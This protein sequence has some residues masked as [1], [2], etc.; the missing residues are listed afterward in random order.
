MARPH[1]GRRDSKSA[2]QAA[3]VRD[4][5]HG[6]Q[7]QPTVL[8][9]VSLPRHPAAHRHW[10]I[11][12]EPDRDRLNHVEVAIT[13]NGEPIEALVSFPIP[14]LIPRLPHEYA[15]WLPLSPSP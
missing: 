13:H 5:S 4:L 6:L 2:Q 14:L 3:L 12:V 8:V 1:G 7:L 11:P 15:A 10:D 9:D